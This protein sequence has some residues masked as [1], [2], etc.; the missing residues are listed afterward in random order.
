MIEIIYQ[1][2]SFKKN[3]SK[4][5]TDNTNFNRFFYAES[6]PS[7][8]PTTDVAKA[9][10]KT[11]VALL[12]IS[13]KW[14]IGRIKAMPSIGILNIP[15]VA[16]TMTKLALGTPAIPLLVSISTKSIVI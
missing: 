12:N 13:Q 4:N 14:S 1:K 5:R 3:R 9:F 10:P 2:N 7:H 11:L 6:S 16:A 15:Q 8:F